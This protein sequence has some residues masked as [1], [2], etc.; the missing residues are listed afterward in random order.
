M[1]DNKFSLEDL[2]EQ[3]NNY[4]PEQQMEM[5]AKSIGEGAKNLA[6]A[7]AVMKECVDKMPSLIE[8]MK[9]ANMVWV[10]EEAKDSIVNAGKETGTAAANAF[11]AEVEQVIKK[12]RT[13]VNHISIPANGAYCLLMTLLSLFA[14]AVLIVFANYWIWNHDLI[15]QT[16][17]IIGGYIVVTNAIIIYLIHKGW[18]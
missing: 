15:W 1:K 14:F 9:K 7:S 17:A 2:R 8:E 12:S 6:D 13:K 16:T 5:D 3:L 18:M 10:S 4:S 11:R